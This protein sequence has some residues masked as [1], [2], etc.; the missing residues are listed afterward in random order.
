MENKIQTQPTARVQ[1]ELNLGEQLNVLIS[2]SHALNVRTAALFD[3][4]I[5]PAEFLILD[6]A[7]RTKNERKTY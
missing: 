3:P 7:G 1:L 4:A 5:Q 6:E 2:E